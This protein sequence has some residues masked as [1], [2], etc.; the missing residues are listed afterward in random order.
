MT[1]YYLHNVRGEKCKFLEYE[2]MRQRIANLYIPPNAYI[3]IL[4]RLPMMLRKVSLVGKGCNRFYQIILQTSHNVILQL[5]HKWESLLNEEI[6]THEI[7]TGFSTIHRIPK[8]VYN[9]YVQFRI[10][11]DRLN[12]RKHLYKM[13]ITSNDKCIY[14]NDKIDTNIHALLECPLTA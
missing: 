7:E 6:N 9:E 4:P 1:L 2:S 14:C 3:S 13:K 5:K 8:C 10:L 11:H 12:T